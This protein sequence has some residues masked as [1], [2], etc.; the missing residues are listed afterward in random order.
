MLVAAGYIFNAAHTTVA[1]VLAFEVVGGTYARQ[2]VVSRTVAIDLMGD[3]ALLRAASTLFPALSGVTP[4]GAIL[5]RQV[6]GDDTTPGNDPLVAHL[7]FVAP[8]STT[9]RDLLVEYPTPGA[10]SVR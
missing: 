4:A 1:D 9:G 5:Y 8:I 7:G 3:R 2:D 6:G 10:L